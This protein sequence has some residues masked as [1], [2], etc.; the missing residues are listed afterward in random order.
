MVSQQFKKTTISVVIDSFT[1][2]KFAELQGNNINSFTD[3]ITLDLGV[4]Y[5]LIS[6]T[7]LVRCPFLCRTETRHPLVLTVIM[8]VAMILSPLVVGAFSECLE[9]E[10]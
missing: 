6:K 4:G 1:D 10:S 8:S 2:V 5:Q 7:V 3:I 9:G